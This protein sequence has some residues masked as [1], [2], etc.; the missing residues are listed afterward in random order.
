MAINSTRRGKG[1]E[2]IF[3]QL[4][5][6]LHHFFPSPSPAPFTLLGKQHPPSSGSG[7][8]LWALCA[9][10][11][12]PWGWEMSPCPLAGLGLAAQHQGLAG[13]YGEVATQPQAP[14]QLCH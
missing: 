11:G 10:P 7:V 14:S 8:L 12:S 5:W 13:E 4:S 2:V 3:L 1:D 6:Y 9:P